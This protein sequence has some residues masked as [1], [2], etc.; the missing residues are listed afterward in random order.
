MQTL[1]L[2]DKKARKGKG[3]Q[4]GVQ[5]FD[6]DREQNLL[7]LQHMLQTK[8]YRTSSYTNFVIKERKERLVSR[9]PYFPDRITHHAIMIPLKPIFLSTFTADTYS[10]IE[11]RGIHA[12]AENMVRM[13]KDKEGTMYYAQLD[14]EKFFPSV[15]HEVLKNLLRK[16]IKDRDLLWLLD[17]IIDSAP[18]LPIGNYLSQ[19]F[20][21]FYLTYFDHWIKEEMKMPYYLRYCDDMIFMYRNKWKLQGLVNAIIDYLGRNL[22]L[23]I[24]PNWKI[25]PVRCGIDALGYEFYH[26]HILI[27]KGIKQS[28]ARMLSVRPNPQSIA[29]YLGWLK[30]ANCTNLS[31]KLLAAA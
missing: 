3:Q 28:F 1:E 8:T 19:Y 9:L 26:D 17:E 15:D 10:C 20:S 6:R 21:N 27:R 29:S 12:G 13:L 30:H 14:V 2:A 16:K 18:G 25:E 24:K 7:S 31:K 4:Y 22:K 11:N 5:L 23:K